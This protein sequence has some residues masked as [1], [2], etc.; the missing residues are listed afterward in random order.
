[1]LGKFFESTTNRLLDKRSS[2]SRTSILMGTLA[3]VFAGVFLVLAL[4]W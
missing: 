1:M 4:C 3:V 2:W